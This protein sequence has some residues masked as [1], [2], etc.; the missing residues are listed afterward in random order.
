MQQDLDI[1]LHA[2]SGYSGL[3][4]AEKKAAATRLKRLLAGNNALRVEPMAMALGMIWVP[5]LHR[6]NMRPSARDA[7]AS[8]AT[9]DTI[10]SWHSLWQQKV[11]PLFKQAADQAV[12]ARKEAATLNL[13]LI[14]I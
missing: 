13:S 14:H 8:D 12:G 11:M 9:E 4:T 3:P 5:N 6:I 2:A 1:S 10:L 7:G